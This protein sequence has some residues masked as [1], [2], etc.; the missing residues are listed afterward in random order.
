MS[1]N[2][3]RYFDGILGYGIVNYIGDVGVFK[4]KAVKKTAPNSFAMSYGAK[5]I[6]IWR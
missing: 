6:N 2:E 5:H 1:K 3:E 4:Q